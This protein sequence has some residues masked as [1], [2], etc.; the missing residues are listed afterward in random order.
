MNT[1]MTSTDQPEL[2]ESRKPREASDGA[3]ALSDGDYACER[4]AAL[5]LQRNLLPRRLRGGIA[6]EAASRYLPAD[7]EAG[8]GGDWFDVIPLSGARVALVVGDVVGHGIDA[9][10]TMGRLRTAVRTLADLDLPPDELLRHLDD[11][12][13]RL[14]DEDGDTPEQAPVMGATCLYAVYDPITRHCTMAQAGHLPPAII[15]PHGHVTFPDLP[16]GAPLGLGLGL[17]PFEAVDVELPE[18]SLLA[19]Y[20]DGLVE[21]RDEDIDDGIHRL[22]ATLAHPD[23]SLEDLCSSAM[24]SLPARAPSDDITLLL[25]RIRT[26]NASQIASWDLTTEPA[27]VR[28]ARHLA[29]RQLSEWGLEHLVSTTELVVSEL[30]TNA[31]RHG[32]GPIRLRLIQHNVLTCEVFDSG[33]CSP[34]VRHARII[35]ENGRGLYMV[36]QVSRRWGFRSAT[37]GKLV[38]VEQDLASAPAHS[39][40]LCPPQAADAHPARIA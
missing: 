17:V 1:E 12:V 26:L 37:E 30:V 29:A 32:A 21:S 34:R 35:D 22:V 15:D 3:R 23:Q 13:R 25:V 27:V 14:I 18:G 8:V 4:A 28:T 24:E 20:T 33:I 31:I 6:V 11:S 9:A 19:L 38:W 5:E 39:H 40:G 10:A 36:A 7:T 16:T 2:A